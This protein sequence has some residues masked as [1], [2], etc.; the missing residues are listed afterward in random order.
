MDTIKISDDKK[1]K[2]I[3]EMFNKKFPHL[4]I[5]FFSEDHDEGEATS[6][7]SMYDDELYLKDIRKNNNEGEL[8]INGNN[9]TSTFESNFKE[10]FGVNVQVWRK[11]GNMWLQ[12]TSTDEWTLSEQERKGFEYDRN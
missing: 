11:S 2:D 1:L 3:K 12:T 5:E 8:S 7:K 4:K 9:K 6:F 10:H